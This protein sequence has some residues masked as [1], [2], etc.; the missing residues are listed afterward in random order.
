MAYIAKP[1]VNGY[2]NEKI[3]EGRWIIRN[4]WWV[5]NW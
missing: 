4:I 2:L 3:I 5:F 1:F